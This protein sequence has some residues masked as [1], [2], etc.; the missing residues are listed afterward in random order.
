[1]I[2][3]T[4]KHFQILTKRHSDFDFP[5][6]SKPVLNIAAQNSKATQVKTVG[7]MKELFTEFLATAQDAGHSV[8]AWEEFYF[9]RYNG[10]EKIALATDKLWAMLSKMPLDTT[11][12]NKEVANAYIIDLVINKTHY[13]M[14]GEYYAVLATAM[15]FKLNYRFSTAEEESQGI[16]A[17]IGNKP[18]QVKPHDSVTKHHVRNHADINKTLVITYES[19]ADRCYIHNPEFMDVHNGIFS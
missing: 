3:L 19:K 5:K 2:K 13:G 9:T 12:L 10:R 4:A 7:S 18:V 17:W 6:Y 14:S 15:H 11:I 8:E 1:M 16:D